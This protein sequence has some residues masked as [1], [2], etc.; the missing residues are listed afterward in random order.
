MKSKYIRQKLENIYFVYLC[1]YRTSALLFTAFWG[2]FL[3]FGFLAT[4]SKLHAVKTKV[5]IK[6][7]FVNAGH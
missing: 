4:H 6:D 5:K 1:F 2:V 3:L 7:S